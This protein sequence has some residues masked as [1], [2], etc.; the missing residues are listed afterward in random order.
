M[1]PDNPD[2]V[3]AAI[4]LGPELMMQPRDEQARACGA[5]SVF[6]KL[7]RESVSISFFSRHPDGVFP[8]I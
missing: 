5:D 3:R 6:K 4:L 7:A 2:S 8:A 1:D